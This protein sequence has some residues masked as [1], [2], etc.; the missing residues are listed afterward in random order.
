MSPLHADLWD[1]EGNL[2]IPRYGI[3][4]AMCLALLAAGAFWL[5]EFLADTESHKLYP[6]QPSEFPDSVWRTIQ[7]MALPLVPYL[8]SGLLLSRRSEEAKAAG[9]GVAGGLF[10]CS[11]PFSIF[12]V[13]GLGFFTGPKPYALPILISSLTFSVCGI[14]IVVS[15]FLIA[16]KAG[17]GV[18]FLALPATLAAMT[19]AS[20]MLGS[21]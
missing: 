12:S 15:A 16:R 11:L 9:A 8:V 13:L 19:F 2:L 14:W 21:H 17:W 20:H 6:L 10:L 5:F 4:I 3:R 7:W 1:S 18:F